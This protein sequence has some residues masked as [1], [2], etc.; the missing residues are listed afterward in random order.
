MPG[1]SI[2][3]G[4]FTFLDRH[5]TSDSVTSVAPFLGSDQVTISYMSFT[6]TSLSTY[7]NASYY[8]GATIANTMH[9]SLQY[10]FCKSGGVLATELTRWTAELQEPRMA[11]LEWSVVNETA[12]R[13]YRIQRSSDGQSFTNL[14]ALPGAPNGSGTNGAP[15][16]GARDYAWSDPLPDGATGKFYYRLEIDDKG[17]LSYSPVRQIALAADFQGIRIYPN[18]ATDFINLVPGQGPG[19]NWQIDILSA[20]GSL[21]QREIFMQAGT[22]HLSFR[23]KMSAGTYFV[24]AL[25]LRGQKSYTSSFI[26]IGG[27]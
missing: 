18:P 3:Q 20:G 19:G 9:F 15:N 21:I 5:I 12:G 17:S 13:R 2:S 14:A 4:P 23:G 26:V 1:Q 27:R 25:D 8:Y 24:R 7:N 11:R 22:M 16:G 6:Y 10:L